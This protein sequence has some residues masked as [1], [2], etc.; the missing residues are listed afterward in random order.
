M[1]VTTPLPIP[2]LS[3]TKPVRVPKCPD[4]FVPTGAYPQRMKH[5]AIWHH[6]RENARAPGVAFPP[7]SAASLMRCS[8][9]PVLWGTDFRLSKLARQTAQM[10]PPD[11]RAPSQLATP[12][13][14]GTIGMPLCWFMDPFWAALKKKIR[15]ATSLTRRKQI[16]LHFPMPLEGFE[17]L[18][19]A[20]PD[21]CTPGLL[22]GVDGSLEPT[23]RSAASQ[24][25]H[26]LLQ[27]A[28]LIDKVF[29]MEKSDQCKGST[30]R[31]V[32]PLARRGLG[33][34]RLIL[35]KR[36]CRKGSRATLLS[37]MAGAVSVR[38][39]VPARGESMPMLH[40]AFFVATMDS[41]GHITWPTT[42]QPPTRSILR[43]AAR[44][45]LQKM[46][47]GQYPVAASFAQALTKE[48]DSYLSLRDVQAAASA[49]RGP[50]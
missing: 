39:V 2:P 11:F 34:A 49:M 46:I 22:R 33:A 45:A 23:K 41:N 16:T 5:S 32:R 15:P 43:K 48:S 38:L 31:L 14:A 24:V 50:V 20:L 4:N 29:T 19:S 13:P 35:G 1:I 28:S 18:L 12:V 3:I 17:E 27:K 26:Y 7:Q 8:P 21:G 9:R 47:D 40:L 10:P 25:Y 42:F 30:K 44:R 36:A 37:L 6:S